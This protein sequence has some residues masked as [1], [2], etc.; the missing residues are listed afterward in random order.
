MTCDCRVDDVGGVPAA[1][2]ADLDDADVDGRVGER[3]EGHRRQQ[4]EERDALGGLRIDELDVRDDLV[5]GLDE[6]LGGH[7]LAVDADALGHRLQV[8]RGVATGAQAE[9]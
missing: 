1:A 2:H 9:G 6:D 5:V 7:R 8:R 4:L 3:A